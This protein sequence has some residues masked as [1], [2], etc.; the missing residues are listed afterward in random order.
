MNTVYR[1]VSN[2]SN[3]DIKRERKFLHV[4]SHDFRCV[5]LT[6]KFLEQSNINLRSSMKR[7]QIPDCKICTI[8]GLLKIIYELN[9]LDGMIKL[10]TANVSSNV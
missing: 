8:G 2:Y 10:S 9:A 1:I 4:F 3:Q 7:I 5:N 6:L